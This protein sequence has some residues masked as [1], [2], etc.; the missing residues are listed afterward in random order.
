MS[1]T[2]AS[3]HAA[4]GA[5]L[6]TGEPFATA[7]I[8]RVSGS[9]PNGLGARMVVGAAG[10]LL[11][12]TI[13]GGR[14]EF[15]ALA[16]CADAIREGRSRMFSAKLTDKESG[17]LGMMCGGNADVFIE[18]HAPSPAVILC[19][20]GHINLALARMA[21]G[22]DLRLTVIDD[23]AD[24]ASEANFPNCVRILARPEAVLETLGLDARACVVIG[25]RDGDKD[26][27]AA[28]A[29]TDAGYIGVVA[30][31]RK[32][33]LLGRELAERLDAD[34]MARLLP[35]FHAPIG[36]DLGGRSPEAVALSI[37]AELQA[38]RYGRPGGPMRLGVEALTDYLERPRAHG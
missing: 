16:A 2:Y 8:V 32:A 28:A 13:G 24:W 12:G 34:A 25:T 38:H 15:E 3:V 20:A 37:L 10:A 5:L 29:A 6:E 22:L 31:R 27:I 35:R 19:G 4:I 1:D 36:L 26:A 14:I 30:S 23:R 21:E 11:A 33:I 9:I 18:V 17:G 7:Q